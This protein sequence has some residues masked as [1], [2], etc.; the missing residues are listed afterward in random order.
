MLIGDRDKMLMAVSC[1]L[2]DSVRQTGSG[3]I[4]L[5]VF[6]KETDGTEHLLVSVKD[7]GDGKG[8]EAMT[9]LG[10]NIASEILS[11][12]GSELKTI[13]E[14]GSGS[15]LYFEIDQETA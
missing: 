1:M 12:M 7:T 3:S 11:V 15:E 9:G 8:G 6:G 2:L 4:K 13:R 14:E 5:S 10:I